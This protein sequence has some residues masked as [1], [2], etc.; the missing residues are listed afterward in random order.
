MADDRLKYYTQ[1]M[2]IDTKTDK[3]M[4]KVAI[5][6]GNYVRKSTD[7]RPIG[8]E[9][10]TLYLWDTKESFISDGIDWRAL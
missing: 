4:P 7:P 8:N 1:A 5:E 10:D 2:E 6:S 3:P 9:G